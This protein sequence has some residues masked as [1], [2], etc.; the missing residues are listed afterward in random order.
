MSSVQLSAIIT[1]YNSEAFIAEAIQS[2]LSQTIPVDEIIVVDDG[3]N[4]RTSEIVLQ[5]K[6]FGVRY[7]YQNNQGPSAAR[8]RGAHEARGEYIAFLDADDL[9]LSDKT[10]K[11]LTYLL[12]HPE[13]SLISGMVWVWDFDTNRQTL[14]VIKPKNEKKIPLDLLIDNIIGNPSMTIIKKEAFDN[15]G[16]YNPL[17][18][19]G[20]DWDLW[21]RISEKYKLF[22]LP[23]PVIVYRSHA[24]NLSHS[25]RWEKYNKT[26]QISKL[27]ILKSKWSYFQP[28]LLARSF[29]NICLEKAMY[30]F[31]NGFPFW[32]QIM[33]SVLSLIIFPFDNLVK[34]ARMLFWSVVGRTVERKFKFW[35]DTRK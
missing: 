9:W 11:Q 24:A 23:E 33:Y 17:L 21:I 22:I 6:K 34:K 3:S 35:I 1:A 31:E 28:F 8:N 12:T 4:D 27:A 30:S 18:R 2:I 14:D 25:D 19:W 7:I 13:L 16:G 26:W 20:E 5:Y 29:S 32:K 10:E 15:I